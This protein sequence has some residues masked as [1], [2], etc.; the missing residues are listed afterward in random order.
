M[1]KGSKAQ[2]AKDGPS[3]EQRPINVCPSLFHLVLFIAQRND[4]A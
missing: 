2:G 1:V 4:H 3:S